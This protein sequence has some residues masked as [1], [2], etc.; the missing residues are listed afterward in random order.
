MVLTAVASTVM[1]IEFLTPTPINQYIQTSPKQNKHIIVTADKGVALIVM[2]KTEYITKCE[3]L[4][5]DNSV[6]KHLS[7]DTSP[8]IVIKYY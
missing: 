6:Y 5:Q 8:A 2:D 4:L 7:K 3:A 1:S